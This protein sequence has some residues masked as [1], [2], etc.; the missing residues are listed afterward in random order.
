M[1]GY[2]LVFTEIDCSK[3]TEDMKKT[4]AEYEIEGYPTIKLIK[5][6]QVIEY[7]AKPDKD[8]IEKFIN[9]VV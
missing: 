8:T 4:T 1:N 3:E 5:D 2:T 9:T 7:D 6:G